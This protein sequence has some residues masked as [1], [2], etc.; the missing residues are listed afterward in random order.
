VSRGLADSVVGYEISETAAEYVRNRQL[1]GVEA[2]HAFDGVDLSGEPDDSYDLAVLSEV[3]EH[4]GQPVE[5]LGEAR[6]LA[7]TVAVQ[8]FLTDTL[9]SRRR[10][11][12]QEE[13]KKLHR[14]NRFNVDSARETLAAV[15]L[16]VVHD[17]VSQ[18]SFVERT[19][20]DRSP[21]SLAKESVVEVF[22]RVPPVGRR[23]FGSTYTAICRRSRFA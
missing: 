11:N 22:Q 13:E 4:A 15:G 5:L 3:I 1:E 17:D 20:W 8:V 12:Q 6:R 9:A 10:A 18:P 16:K 21:R 14:L 7:H 19:F 23:L 2:V